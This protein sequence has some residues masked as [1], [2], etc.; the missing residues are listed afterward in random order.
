M[1]IAVDLRKISNNP[2]GIGY[3]TLNNIK[4]MVK[5]GTL[6][7]L[8]FTDVLEGKALLDL[9]QLIEIFAFGREVA[10]NFAVF[11]YFNFIQ[12][13]L[14]E[15]KPEFF[16]E[17]NFIMPRSLKKKASDTKYLITVHDVIPVSHPQF[18]SYIYHFYFKFFLKKTISWIDGIIYI[19][20][21][22]KEQC[23]KF[24]PDSIGK[25]SKVI[26][27]I[28]GDKDAIEYYQHGD[29]KECYFLYVGNLEKR[30]GISILINAF[31]KY[32]KAGGQYDLVICGDQ[33]DVNI[34]QLLSKIDKNTMKKIKYLGYVSGDTKNK[35]L[36]DSKALI[37]PSYV[38]GF[39]LPPMEALLH[40]KEIIVSD[41]SV[42]KEILGANATYFHIDQTNE[43]SSK[44]LKEAMLNSKNKKIPRNSQLLFEKYNN[45]IS[46]MQILEFLK[47]L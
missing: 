47:S 18:C 33:K 16:W 42:H 6:E 25:S 15:L 8:G 36:R 32:R 21:S 45:Q 13:K 3:Y 43:Q 20:N 14:I 17:P 34:N 41:I 5:I 44:N 39:G 2:S 35:L 31:D 1:R 4:E 22:T 29:G 19:S 10:N 23:E 27:P 12:N 9:H 40:G 30:K 11:E 7:I 46:V 24:F 26:Y 37:Y 38:E 28:I